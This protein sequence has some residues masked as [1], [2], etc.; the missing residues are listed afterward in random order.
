MYKIHCGLKGNVSPGAVYR[1]E[2][3]IKPYDAWTKWLKGMIDQMN[4]TWNEQCVLSFSF[5]KV[6]MMNSFCGAF[7]SL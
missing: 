5:F 7:W 3:D 6:E 2:L 4:F 1:A